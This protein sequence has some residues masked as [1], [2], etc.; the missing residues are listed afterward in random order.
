M[1]KKLSNA[2]YR[3]AGTNSG[4]G[5]YGDVTTSAEYANAVVFNTPSE[6]PTWALVQTELAAEDWVDV[7]GERD[8]LLA[9]CDWTQNSDSPLS[10]SSK[11]AWANYRQQLRDVPQ[12]NA[13][14]NN[15]SWPTAP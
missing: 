9:R 8:I 7:R 14:P 4:F 6:K 1:S 15:I 11:S 3:A 2:I 10:E 13:D 5:I 12:D